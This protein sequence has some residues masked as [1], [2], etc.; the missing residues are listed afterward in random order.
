MAY[1]DVSLF[2]QQSW[3]GAGQTKENEQDGGLAI[4][5]SVIKIMPNYELYKLDRNDFTAVVGVTQVKVSIGL[6]SEWASLNYPAIP[7]FFNTLSVLGGGG[8]IGSVYMS[9]KL[10]RKNGFISMTPTFRVVDWNGTGKPLMAALQ[11]SKLCLP[12][13]PSSLATMIN[14]AEEKEINA[15]D[16][17]SENVIKASKTFK[18]SIKKITKGTAYEAAGDLIG[19]GIESTGKAVGGRSSTINRNIVEDAHDLI[20]LKDAPPPVMVQISNYFFHPDMIITNANFEFSQEVSDVGPL[21]VD[22]TLEMSTRKRVSGINDIGF[23]DTVN[24]QR[25]EYGE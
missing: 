10:W 1:E 18:D 6:E 12:G 15:V 21:Y 17:L 2:N 5:H 23:T 8:E 3:Q 13:I 22:I 4:G 9:K 24:V 19:N 16:G 7:K 14:G 20:T 25:V 11:V